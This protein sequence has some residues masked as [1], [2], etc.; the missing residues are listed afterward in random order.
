MEVALFNNVGL[1][2]A[3]AHSR[4]PNNLHDIHGFTL[5]KHKFHAKHHTNKYINLYN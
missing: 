5:M 2:L 4:N 1:I 3:E